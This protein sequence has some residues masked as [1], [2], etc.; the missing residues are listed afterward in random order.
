M[1]KR[2]LAIDDERELISAHVLA[3]TYSDGK[4]ALEKLGPWHTLYLDNDLGAIERQYFDTGRELEGYDICCLL[5]QSP[6]LRPQEIVLVTNNTSALV[7]M[8][9]CLARIYQN[10]NPNKLIF[11]N[12]RKE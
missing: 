8:Q 5:E 11:W 4:L 3:R 12:P 10:H 9:G 7:K 1:N 6:D 2:I